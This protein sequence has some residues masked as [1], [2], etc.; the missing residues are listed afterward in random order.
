MSKFTRFLEKSFFLKKNLKYQQ[1]I[2]SWR[3]RFIF[4]TELDSTDCSIGVLERLGTFLK[5]RYASNSNSWFLA[6]L[7]Q[8]GFPEG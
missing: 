8:M 3:Y 7:Y 1:S 4:S 6:I 2:G 5:W